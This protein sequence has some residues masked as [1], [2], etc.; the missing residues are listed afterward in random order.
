[1]PAHSAPGQAGVSAPTPSAS[2]SPVS[3]P[4]LAQA[5]S[6]KLSARQAKKPARRAPEHSS[7]HSRPSCAADRSQSNPPPSAAHSTACR[8]P[9][10]ANGASRY[11]QPSGVTQS[12]IGPPRL[13][14]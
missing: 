9:L 4:A 13:K 6:G 11:A 7:A 5:A 10:R 3:M 14:R 2:T 8:A 12:T 1:M